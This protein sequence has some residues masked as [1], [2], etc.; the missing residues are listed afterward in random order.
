MIFLHGITSNKETWLP[1]I[2]VCMESSFFSLIK[3]NFSSMLFKNIPSNYHCIA[4]DLPAHGETIG[5]NE[6]Q[7]S[8]DKFAE[9]LKLVI[10]LIVFLYNCSIFFVVVVFR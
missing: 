2:K 1:I 9:K 7:Y 10:Y 8:A 5:L 6:D 4:I 3:I